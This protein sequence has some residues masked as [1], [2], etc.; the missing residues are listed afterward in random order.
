VCTRP[1]SKGSVPFPPSSSFR[2][3]P[4][5]LSLVLARHPVLR[6]MECRWSKVVLEMIKWYNG[7]IRSPGL[8]VKV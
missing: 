6:A 3:Y 2:V 8:A 1:P 7:V 4:Q 5:R